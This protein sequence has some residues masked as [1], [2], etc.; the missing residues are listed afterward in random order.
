MH[1]YKNKIGFLVLIMSVFSFAMVD[2]PKLKI[3]GWGY[4]TY[5][6]IVSSLAQSQKGVKDFD[7]DGQL[8][9]DFDAG[10][11]TEISLGNNGKGRFHVGLTTAFMM[12]DRELKNVELKRRRF[13]AYLID[14]A[15]EYTLKNN[16]STF[17]TEFG[18]LPIKYNQ[19]ARNL[20]EY[21][22]RSNSYPNLVVSGFELSDKEKIVGWHG[23]YQNDFT[24]KTWFRGDLFFHTETSLYPGYN[25]SLSYML[26][27]NIN[28]F[29]QLGAGLS[30]QHLIPINK[31]KTTPGNDR[32]QYNRNT[33][34]F[35]K[36]GYIGSDDDTIL[37]TFKGTKA[38]GRIT[39]DPKALFNS[40]IFGS[41]DFKI[42]SEMAILGLKDYDY[43]YDNRAERMPFMFG[44]NFPTFKI[45]D[46]LAIEMQY[47]KYPWSNNAENIWRHGSP[48]PYMTNGIN[49]GDFPI[50]TEAD[51]MRIHDDDLRWS[52]YASRKIMNRIRIS[53]QFASDN[54]SKTTF[55]P[56][57]PSFTKYTE[58]MPRTK[59][60]YWASRIQFY[61]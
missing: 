13:V 38:M 33:D 40:P 59:D 20:G 25:L 60:W 44:F 54:M 34:E 12:I 7:M 18:Y 53:L 51:T 39:I 17:F 31:L 1:N 4:L 50:Y 47:W 26:S 21:L 61:F 30:H 2:T 49:G 57:P 15:V 23:M 37:Y 55:S 41:E 3:S 36:V 8:F 45:L 16:N 35:L 32:E 29:I 6:K 43:W 46:V 56:P 10:L 28:N 52:I 27:A 14:A 9:S 19:Q 58:V 5:G 22:F 24:D 42:Y 11:K 48:L